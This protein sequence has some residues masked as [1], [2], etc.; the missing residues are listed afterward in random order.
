MK[1]SIKKA[2]DIVMD[3]NVQ[4]Q[5]SWS[6]LRTT[7]P[8]FELEYSR[9]VQAMKCALEAHYKDYDYHLFQNKIKTLL[10]GA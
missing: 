3:K 6:G 5:L 2:L 7:K 10:Q 4:K 1:K 9:I 8:S